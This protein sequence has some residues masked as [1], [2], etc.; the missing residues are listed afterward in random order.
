MIFELH[1]A[2]LMLA[3]VRMSSNINHTISY[4]N[5]MWNHKVVLSHILLIKHF[6]KNLGQYDRPRVLGCKPL[7]GALVV[8]SSN[9]LNIA[10]FVHQMGDVCL[11]PSGE[12]KW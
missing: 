6:T 3:C 8:R 2:G 12:Q 9:Q 11:L 1:A 10:Q 7:D 5:I 4:Q